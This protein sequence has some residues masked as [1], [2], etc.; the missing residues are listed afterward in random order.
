[1]FHNAV[2]CLVRQYE[3]FMRRF[4][5][6]LFLPS[7][8]VPSPP[9]PPLLLLSQWLEGSQ[10]CTF[11]FA[12]HRTTDVSGKA[13]L[14]AP[15]SISR[16]LRLCVWSLSR[17]RCSLAERARE[18]R[19]IASKLK[20]TAC[21]TSPLAGSA[22]ARPTIPAITF[23]FHYGDCFRQFSPHFPTTARE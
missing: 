3:S 8:P 5:P 2:G 14:V 9:P 23:Y 4:C 22:S 1:V 21:P 10:R 7:H 16:E 6:S 17:I 11:T 12:E 19:K 15:S 18:P 13:E 20:I